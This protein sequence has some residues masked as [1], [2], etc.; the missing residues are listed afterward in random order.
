MNDIMSRIISNINKKKCAICEKSIDI[1]RL[2]IC[3]NCGN[4]CA[5]VI[6]NVIESKNSYALA[7]LKSD[8]CNTDI[9]ISSKTTCSDKCHEK[10]LEIFE[11]EFGKFKKVTDITTEISY[12]VPTKDIIEKGLQWADLPKYPIWAED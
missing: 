4:L 10:L 9:K 5:D 1:E 12:K 8:C 3:I 7:D 11:N 2:T 6:A